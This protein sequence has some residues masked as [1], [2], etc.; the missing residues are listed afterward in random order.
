MVGNGIEGEVKINA[1]E[2]NV[3]DEK[4]MN[5]YSVPLVNDKGEY[6][7]ITVKEFIVLCNKHKKLVID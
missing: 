4:V 1:N 6:S 5:E 3:S 7:Y 2:K